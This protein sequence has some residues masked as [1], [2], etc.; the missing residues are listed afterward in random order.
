[1]IRIATIS[2]RNLLK[3]MFT[4]FYTSDA[5]LHSIPQAYHETALDELFSPASRQRA[6]LL[7]DGETPV[8]YA[9]ISEKFS[10]E[11]GGLELWVEELYL[12]EA[13]RGKGFG[14][15]FFR[16]LLETAQKEGIARV[17]L[18]VEPEN[19]RAAALY[20]K[21]GFQTLPYN[22]MAWTPEGTV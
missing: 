14:S 13:A 19:T 22:Q 5:V 2:D 20:A 12:R 11:A 9:L 7:E 10:H 6:Y 18:E 3:T 17:R 8:G 21:L 1:M 16:C 15:A 4:E